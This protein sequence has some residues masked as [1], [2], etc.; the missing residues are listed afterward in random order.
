[1]RSNTWWTVHGARS[2][3]RRSEAAAHSAP[4]WCSVS[5]GC[6]L[7]LP[8][9]TRPASPSP[10]LTTTTTPPLALFA[11][12]SDAN[13]LLAAPSMNGSGGGG[14]TA[15]AL[16]GAGGGGPGGGPENGKAGADVVDLTLDSSSSS[17]DE[18]EDEEDDED[19][20]D[21]GPRP[22]RRCPFPKGLVSAC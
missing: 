9:S 6:P 17:E 16:G 22:K 5:Q 2:G 8:P 21:E 7:P 4:S 14:G 13:G 1:M 3:L 10:T 11:G 15:G 20:D 19:E 18:D 12:N